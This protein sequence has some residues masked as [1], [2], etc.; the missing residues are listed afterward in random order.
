MASDYLL[1]LDGIKGESVD[2]KFP[3]AIEID[4][5]SW[6]CSNG[7]SFSSGTGGGAGKASAQDFHFTTR[8]SKASPDLL[9][10]CATGKAISK[11]TLHLRKQGEDGQLEFYT[12]EMTDCL[13]SSFQTGGSDGSSTLPTDQVS[14]NFAKIKIEYKDQSNQ[15]KLKA[16]SMFGYNFQKNKSE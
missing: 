5:F 10:R 15:N 8:C 2:N 14:F 3:G 9:N 7:G 12:W 11:A 6:G 16:P 1:E 13:I 4:S